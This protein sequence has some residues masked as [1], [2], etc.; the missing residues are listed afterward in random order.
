MVQFSKI[1][2]PEKGLK[3]ETTVPKRELRLK[4]V[5][6]SLDKR[7]LKTDGVEALYNALLN[8]A[9]EVRE[10]VIKDQG[11]SPS[12]IL[13]LIHEIISKEQIDNF[14][15]Y[16]LIVT[17]DYGL[18]SHDIS[19]TAA[20]LKVGKG[21]NYDLKGLLKLGL[22]AFFQNIGMYK[23]P[24]KIVNKKGKLTK[25]ESELIK[26]H[27]QFSYE[28]LLKMGK[29]FRWLAEIALQ[30]H[31]RYDG[32]GYPHGLKG[33]EISEYALIIGLVDMYIAMIRHRPYREKF[34]QT[35]AI[36]S[37]LEIGKGKFPPYIVKAFLNQITLFPINTYVRLNNNAIGRVISTDENKP[38]RP[39]VEI[40][41]DSRGRRLSNPQIVD[42][43]DSP[44]LH[45]TDTIDE[46]S[47]RK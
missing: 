18:P 21:L 3:K 27:P 8:R 23:I 1:M 39:T 17:D 13:R 22:A 45:I 10:R 15:K 34:I 20:S 29:S 40:I 47:L 14:Y 2:K 5:V 35:E 46:N 30:I 41:F 33:K 12:P 25:E 42:L 43:R 16:T 31:E 9:L 38:M 7:G 24:E 4:E 11:I 37:I 6:P 28:I 44:L 19:V 36:K 26:K 32:S